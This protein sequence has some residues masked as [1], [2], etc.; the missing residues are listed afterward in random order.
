MI[1]KNE[2][3]IITKTFDNLLQTFT[4]SY[5]VICDTGSTDD[6]INVIKHY[7]DKKNIS[8]EIPRHEWK[9]FG[10]NRTLAL[11]AAYGKSDYLLIFDADDSITGS[12][13]LPKK[14][15]ADKYQLI[16]GPG[17]SYTRPLL[18]N[19]RKHWKFVGVLHEYL[20]GLSKTKETDVIITGDYNII[21]G[22]SGARSKNANKYADDA[23]ILRAAILEEPDEM[24]RLRYI[25]YC[26]QS[27]RDA[28]RATEALTYYEKCM[29]SEKS[30]AQERWV[31]CNELGKIHLA[32]GHVQIAL[33]Y[34]LRTTQFD[35][36]RIEGIVS[37]V[38]LLYQQEQYYFIESLYL[39]YRGYKKNP[40]NKLFIS[41]DAYQ[42][43]IFEV[44]YTC[45]LLNCYKYNEGGILSLKL[46]NDKT[47]NA[48]KIMLFKT[49]AKFISNLKQFSEQLFDQ[50]NGLIEKI[51]YD[52]SYLEI[53]NSLFVPERK[54]VITYNP[55]KFPVPSPGNKKNRII[56]T[57]TTCKR[58]DLFK[59]T[60]N[61]ILNTWTDLSKICN[62]FCVDDNSSEEDRKSMKLCYPWIEFYNKTID[63]KGHRK[64]MN[65]IYNKIINCD[66]K[67]WIHME[68]DF[69]F[70]KTKNYV[71]LGIAGFSAF[72]G[73]PVKQVLFNKSYAENIENLLCVSSG[74]P[75]TD[76]VYFLHRYN[77]ETKLFSHDYWPGYSLRPSIT[78][79]DAIKVLGNYDSKNTFF[80]KDYAI[81]WN[82]RG[83]K[84]AFLNEITSLHIGKLTNSEG[85]NAYKLNEETQ[86]SGDKIVIANPKIINL[87]RREDRKAKMITELKKSNFDS[88]IFIPAIDIQPGDY[89]PKFLS[90]LF[91]GN[92][93]N[94]RKGIIG[95]ALSH[96]FLWNQLIN[97][98]EPYYLI[99][100]D[101]IMINKKIPLECA[102]HGIDFLFL[103]YLTETPQKQTDCNLIDG[104]AKVIPLCKEKY[105]GGFH[106]YVITRSGATKM[107]DYIKRNGIKH[108]IDYL[109][110]IC[111]DL[112]CYCYDKLICSVDWTIGTYCADT[113]IQK[114]FDSIHVPALM[115]SSQTEIQQEAETG[116]EPE[117]E[118]NSNKFIFIN[119][120]DMMDNDLFY[121]KINNI[122]DLEKAKKCALDNPNCAGFNSLGFYKTKIDIAKLCP[123]KYFSKTDG[124]YIKI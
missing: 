61:S 1:V 32:Q 107:L 67:Y 81:K 8:G 84:C 112:N 35:P 34:F 49:C 63:E 108:G 115:S 111:P 59:Q 57:F 31:S 12:L 18:I 98:T 27:Y 70:Y 117:T 74:I 6:T 52:K 38:Q 62:W 85:N 121:N 19:N 118:T 123:S 50:F 21:S 15:T 76:G 109:I 89:S 30:W 51:P 17:V 77:A 124:I 40:N 46:N 20:T 13:V 75:S 97:S 90:N 29:N 25:F 28:G 116:I 39:Q 68:D 78:L 5:Y 42:Q 96:F 47:S 4:F 54:R 91:Y 72:P 58:F 120:L 26:A 2:A 56:L 73:E 80:E 92:D 60:I 119:G 93:F 102:A 83:Y 88:H 105:V 65:I 86:F 10:H 24:L 106:S 101:D 41:L 113:D 11:D 71:D 64:S 37:A 3:H 7:F 69:I 16:F 122:D 79:I 95:C 94:N 103:G 99:F 33:N 14:L 22:R 48:M 44:Y 110:K 43:N 82:S 114:S 55:K 100:E 23:E 87:L 9:N 45:S 104:V 36:E 66:C 53:W